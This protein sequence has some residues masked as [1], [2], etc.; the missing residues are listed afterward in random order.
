MEFFKNLSPAIKIIICVIVVI[1]LWP[2]ISFALG[3]LTGIIRLILAI[4][5][6]GIQAILI[7]VIIFIIVRIIKSKK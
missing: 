5:G 2:V 1:A 7:C 3:I 4:L 6:F